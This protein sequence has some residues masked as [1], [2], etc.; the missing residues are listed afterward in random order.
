MKKVSTILP[1]GSTNADLMVACHALK[2]LSNEWDILDPTYGEGAFWNKWRPQW[3]FTSDLN[4][5]TKVDY[6]DN[7]RNLDWPDV[8]FD[9]VVFDPPYKLNGT[10]GSHASDARYGVAKTTRWQDRHQL[11]FYG[12]TECL[13]VTKVGG[14]VL[15]KCM[16]Q[17]VSGHKRWQTR[18][19]ADHAETCGGD[20]VDML[21][22]PGQRAQPGKRSQV[23]SHANYSTLLV[24]QKKRRNDGPTS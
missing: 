19:F 10:A 8:R 4:P 14:F 6:H 1:K 22:L 20:L 12:I 13:R 11:I 18:L 15:I 24:V 9:A 3:L 7:F 21:H 2:Y 5:D 17:V 23:H 16:D